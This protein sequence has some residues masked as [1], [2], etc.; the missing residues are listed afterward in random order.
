MNKSNFLQ[1]KI[2]EVK[3]R[4]LRER[5]Q[6]ELHEAVPEILRRREDLGLM[7]EVESF[8]ENDV[9]EHFKG[10]NP[11][12]YLSR[13]LVTPDYETL[14]FVDQVQKYKFPIVIG[15]DNDDIL[16][17][18]STLKRNLLKLPIITGESKTGH[19]IVQYERIADLNTEQGKKI[20]EVQMLN[21]DSLTAFHHSIAKKLLPKHVLIKDESAWVDRHSR[22]ELITLYES[23]LAL[24]VVHGIMLEYYEIDEIDF[25]Q[26]IVLPALK[27]TKTRFGYTPLI[28]PLKQSHSKKIRDYNSYPKAVKQ[29]INQNL[30][31]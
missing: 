31:F 10:E 27:K 21:G 12:F 22:G 26:E 29:Y 1:R 24:L 25:L 23:M 18:H 4:R 28:A 17:S 6:T 11:I 3:Y 14:L 8:L 13:Y 20:K 5:I 30:N 15:E 16:T 9:P 19:G 7:K 2:K